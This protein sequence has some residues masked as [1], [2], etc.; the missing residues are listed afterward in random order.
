MENNVKILIGV[1]VYSGVKYCFDNFLK[2]IQ[3]IKGFDFDVLI[4]DNSRDDDFFNEIQKRDNLIVIKDNTDEEKNM[5]RLIS[6]RNKILDYASKN[7]YDYLL[8]MDSDVMVPENILLK[9]FDAK[10]DVIS[11]LYFNLFNSGGKQKLLPVCYKE[12]EENIFKEM[13]LRG[14]IPEFV[15]DKSD[16]RR[17]LTPEE[18]EKGEVI[19]VLIP[20]AGC[21]LLSSKAFTSG[22]KY[23][24]LKETNGLRTTDDIGFFKELKNKEFQLYCDPSVYCKHEAFQKYKSN[25]GNHPVYQ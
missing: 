4:V 1:P 17:N 3:N 13:Q 9:L 11:G 25:E 15:K 5:L 2:H 12:I 22:A 7:K 18:I 21:L 16:I 19:E 23:G 14:M 20:S 10:K 8:M 6:S 24:L